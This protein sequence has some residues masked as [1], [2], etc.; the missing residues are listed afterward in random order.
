MIFRADLRIENN[1]MS[2]EIDIFRNKKH[3]S[4]AEKKLSFRTKLS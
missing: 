2:V 1:F 4:A 3:S